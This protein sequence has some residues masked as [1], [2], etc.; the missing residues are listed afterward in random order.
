MVIL[1]IEV[2]FLSNVFLHYLV[3]NYC[4]QIIFLCLEVSIFNSIDR[5]E[6]FVDNR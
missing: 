2:H 1:L 4:I 6:K 3:S 5:N